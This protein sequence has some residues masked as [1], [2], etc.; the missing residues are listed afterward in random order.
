MAIRYMN[1]ASNTHCEIDQLHPK[2]ILLTKNVIL[3]FLQK[4]LDFLTKFVMTSPDNFA[5][6]YFEVF[7]AVPVYR[8]CKHTNVMAHQHMYVRCVQN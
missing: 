8:E 3:V 7:T 1:S 2:E 6:L 5:V 4:L